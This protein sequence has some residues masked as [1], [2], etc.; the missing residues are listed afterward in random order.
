M[1]GAMLKNPLVRGYL[2]ELKA[3]C[4]TLPAGRARELREQITAHLEEAL[5]PGATNAEVD[6]ELRRLGPPRSLAADASGPIP[7]AT[8][9]RNR[10]SRLRWRAWT[11]IAVAVMLIAGAATYLNSVMSAEPLLQG[12]IGI[13]W[14]PQ[15]RNAHGLATTA[16]NVTQI[17]VPE[18][19][20]QQQG[21]VVGIYNLSDWTQTI[22]GPSVASPL[23]GGFSPVRFAVSS[24]SPSAD[25]VTSWTS[26]TGWN[27]PGSIPPHSFRLL[28][29]LWTSRLCLTPGV[30]TS[31]S[32]VTLRVRIGLVTRTEDIQFQTAWALSG[33]RASFPEPACG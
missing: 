7:A 13:W 10:L 15:D 5:P 22:V 28:R 12:S 14:F 8:R 11:A 32:S 1:N 29:I 16:A 21:I 33:T 18:R 20:G 31:L 24:G 25:S 27:L 23:P 6:A 4:A 19:W 26:Q 3:A 30:T 17:S 2:R 9:L